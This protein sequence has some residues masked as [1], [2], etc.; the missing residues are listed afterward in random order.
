MEFL[1]YI[2]QPQLIKYSIVG[3]SGTLVDLITL[4]ILFDVFKVNLYI[5]VTIAFLLA[6]LNNYI[7]NKSWTFQIKTNKNKKF[8]IKFLSVS[9][10]GLIL[11]LF[12]MHVFTFILGF[13]YLLSKILTSSI[14]IAWN[15]LANKYWTFKIK[16]IN[17]EFQPLYD[18]SIIIPAYNEEKRLP[19][20]LSKV[21][22]YLKSQ[23]NFKT[24]EIIVI[25]DGSSDKTNELLKEKSKNN[26]NLK[27]ISYK[28]N[29][30][31]GYAFKKGV[32]NSKGKLTLLTDSDLSTDIYDI[33]KL[34]PHVSKKTPI[35]IGSRYLEKSKISKSQNKFRIF[36]SRFANSLIK[37]FLID[38]INDTQCG[39]KLFDTKTIK[40]IC[41]LQKINGFGF[42]MEILV[43]NQNMMNNVLEVPVTWCN[44]EDSRFR[45]IKHSIKTFREMMYIKLN[46]ISGR[47]DNYYL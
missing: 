39:F 18:L 14:V 37:T 6:V 31:K 46:L 29:K 38:G 13:W 7:F 15:F 28:K 1:K 40:Q 2:K 12:L 22:K 11:S 25:D 32:I 33:E 44:N 3:I 5:S 17:L 30:G 23:S 24:Y 21:I 42:D 47:Y 34:L 4:F 36:I 20:T 16:T 10:I 26:K 19:K 43:I 35:V 45:P 8:F 41:H 9:I 27:F